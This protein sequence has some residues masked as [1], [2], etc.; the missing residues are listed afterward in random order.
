[1]F[2]GTGSDVGKSLVVAGLCRAFANRG[3]KVRPFK[4]QNMSNNAAVAADGGEIGRAQA[5]QARAC[6]VASERAHESGAAEAA[7]RDRRPDR[8]AGAGF[9]LGRRARLSGAETL[10]DDGGPRELRAH[11][12]RSR[13]RAD[14]RRGQRGGD[15]PARRRHRQYGICGKRGLSGGSRRRHRPRRRF[16]ANPRNPSRR[17]RRRIP[18]ASREFLVNKFRGDA[19]LFVDG[20]ALLAARTGWRALG[21]A[22]FFP[23]ACRLPAEDAM[24]L[25]SLKPGPGSRATI[26][27]PLLPSISNFDDLDPLKLEPN[28][29]LVFAR[30][31]EPLPLCDL[32]ILPGSKATIADLAALRAE[33]WDIDIRAHVRRGGK[34]LGLCGGY[35]MLG[36]TIADPDGREGPPARGRGAR[37]SRCRDRPERRASGSLPSKAFV[38]PMARRCRAMRCTSA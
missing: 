33:G 11:D 32:V 25:A 2:Q 34:I 14:R 10:A 28:V 26:V 23:A 5:L 19:S 8:R 17:S 37:P 36:R 3:F 38:S 16:R 1:M 6:R 31:G 4:P 27:A 7:E 30:P 29:R 13:P 15:Q 18:R 20:M 12:E 9:A 22:P 24:A 35:Q 21:L